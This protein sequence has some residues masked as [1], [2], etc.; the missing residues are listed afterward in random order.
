M[1]MFDS[2]ISGI[3]QKGANVQQYKYGVRERNEQEE[4][5]KHMAR[6]SH[7]REMKDL[8]DAGLN[9]ILSAKYG[10]SG[11]ASSTTA[12]QYPNKSPAEGVQV[13]AQIANLKEDTRQKSSQADL[14]S[15]TA[16]KTRVET[17]IPRIKS[18]A[19]TYAE[20]TTQQLINSARNYDKPSYT[21]MRK[22]TTS[23]SSPPIKVP[24]KSI[25]EGY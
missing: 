12:A 20:K 10:G 18:N 3:S 14:N 7:Q 4:F 16:D 5:H 23:P 19:A 21:P 17:V 11:G 15:A 6:T 13:A 22:P 1:G 8:Y 25:R 24:Y 2:I 9:P